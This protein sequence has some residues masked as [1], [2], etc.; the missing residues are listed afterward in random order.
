MEPHTDMVMNGTERRSKGSAICIA[1]LTED[2]QAKPRLAPFPIQRGATIRAE[3]KSN[4]MAAVG[5]AFGSPSSR[6][7]SFG[8]LAPKWKAV[9]VRRW[10][11]L[12]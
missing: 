12:Q 9:P 7:R 2:N 1:Y 6:T 4:A 8:Q 11:A 5:V 3:V 10:R